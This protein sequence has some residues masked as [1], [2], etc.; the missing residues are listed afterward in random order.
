MKTQ[1]NKK[2]MEL[3]VNSAN[4][5]YIPQIFAGRYRNP[6]NFENWDEVK[7]LINSLA[8]AESVDFEDY[9]IFLKHLNV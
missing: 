2:E 4:G 7:D 3:L 1:E 9:W 8:C 5:I 6:E